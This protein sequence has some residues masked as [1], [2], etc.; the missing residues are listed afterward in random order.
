[1][2]N[3]EEERRLSWLAAIIEAEPE[4]GA[5]SGDPQ[6]KRE[7]QQEKAESPKGTGATT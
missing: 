5:F 7:G 1:M 2:A 3:N 6:K 4:S